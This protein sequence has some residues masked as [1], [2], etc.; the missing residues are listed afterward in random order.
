[1]PRA[2]L[3]FAAPC[4]QQAPRIGI[5][6]CAMVFSGCGSD[7]P[8]LLS[9]DTSSQEQDTA[10][11]EDT[12]PPSGVDAY[13]RASLELL[14]EDGGRVDWS[15]DGDWIAFDRCDGEGDIYRLYRIQPDGSEETCLTCDME[16]FEG[17]QVGQPAHHPD[18]EWI[19]FQVEKEVH[20]G[21]SSVAHPGAGLYMDLWAMEVDVR[22]PVVLTDVGGTTPAGGVLH[23]HFSH[24]GE[25]LLWGNRTGS[26]GEFGDW[27]I[28]VAEFETRGDV[29][30]EDIA[31]YDPSAGDEDATDWYEVQ[32]WG[33][34][35]EQIYF[36]ASLQPEQHDYAMDVYRM[37]LASE[38]LERLTSA[39]GVDGESAFWQEHAKLS[40][41]GDVVAYV[42]SNPEEIVE[43]EEDRSQWLVLDLWLMN[44]DG[45]DA[46]R[47]TGFNV[48][49]GYDEYDEGRVRVADFAWSPD[50]SQIALLAIYSNGGNGDQ[51]EKIWLLEFEPFE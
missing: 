18:G 30:L 42:S 51:S 26:S 38:S 8:P 7:D 36:A 45:S 48:D 31:T 17:L 28:A 15:P 24:D 9:D 35:D 41:R 43:D 1:M 37:D 13:V 50:G 6:A 11:P 47:I 49:E 34:E 25:R 40:P 12:A 39:A 14:V 33:L 23:P 19:V 3:S 46:T 22:Q 32:D 21:D 20:Y 27:E 2:P 4:R 5:L 44:P 16:E 29:V 10:P